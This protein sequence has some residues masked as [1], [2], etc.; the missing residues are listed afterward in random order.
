VINI[1]KD[2]GE[3]ELANDYVI[4]RKAADF[5]IPLI[6]NLQLAQRLVEALAK[7]RLDELQ[8]KSW[9]EYA[10]AQPPRPGSAAGGQALRPAA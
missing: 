2:T 7:K 6:T 8:I 3:Q 9:Q 4:R 5:G 1:P 10:A